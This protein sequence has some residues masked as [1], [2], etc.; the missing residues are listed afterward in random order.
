MGISAAATETIATAL[1]AECRRCINTGNDLK[2]LYIRQVLDQ[3]ESATV[4]DLSG[5]TDVP[6]NNFVDGRTPGE[7]TVIT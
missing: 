2:G 5:R 3:L 7:I 6:V 1:I 4:N